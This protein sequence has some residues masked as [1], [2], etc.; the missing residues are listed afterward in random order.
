MSFPNTHTPRLSEIEG[1]ARYQLPMRKGRGGLMTYYLTPELEQHFRRLFP[2]TMNRDMMRLFGVSF[3]TL[4]RFK[5]QLG[6]QKKMRTIRHKQA[7]LAKR[8]CEENGW[9]DSLRGK[10]PSEACFKAAAEKRAAGWHPLKGM[11][12]RNNRKYHRLMAE[13]SRARKELMRRERLRVHCGLEQLTNLRIPYAPIG[14]KR[15]VFRNC[16]KRVGYIPGSGYDER[17]KWIIYYTADTHRGTLREQ[18]GKALGFT[19]QEITDI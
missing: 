9:Y 18:R 16:C 7:Q 14:R 1:K 15:S 12:H 6:L 8:I 3:V 10:Q 5:R 19:F 17:E 11:R 13:K 4:Q 2:V